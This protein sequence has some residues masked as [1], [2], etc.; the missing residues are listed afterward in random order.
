M[1]FSF[2]VSCVC[3]P[4]SLFA[5]QYGLPETIIKNLSHFNSSVYKTWSTKQTV[6]FLI[7]NRHMK[8]ARKEHSE[9]QYLTA[10]VA[11]S[12]FVWEDHG[13]GG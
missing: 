12:N 11:M 4:Y 10:I 13:N 1:F 6:D 5:C 7:A 8:Q 3:F 9:E 2:P